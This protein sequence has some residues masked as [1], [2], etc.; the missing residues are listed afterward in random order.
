[1]EKKMKTITTKYLVFLSI[2]FFVAFHCYAAKVLDYSNRN[3]ADDEI[4]ASL[5][6]PRPMSVSQVCKK[7]SDKISDKIKKYSKAPERSDKLSTLR[8]KI[9]LRDNSISDD[10]ALFISTYFKDNP[11]V[12]SIDLS[13]NYI[14]DRGVKHLEPLLL[15]DNIKEID[16]TNNC[17]ANLASLQKIRD[18]IC[19]KLRIDNFDDSEDSES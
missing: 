17:G 18:E 13:S 6:P 3:I 9:N 19:Y 5:I 12:E 16:I 1:M 4:S 11:F 2:S 14:T 7:I 15:K 10:G 8:V